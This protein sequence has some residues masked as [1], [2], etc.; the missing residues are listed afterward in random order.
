[1]KRIALLASLLV[2]PVI[3]VS[4]ELRVTEAIVFKNGL[5][6]V[7]RQ[8][9]LAFK[10][11]EARIVPA[12]D[13]L[14]GTL[15]IAAGERRV[16][17]ARASKEEVQVESEAT[18]LAALLDVNAGRKVS[19]LID[20]REYTGKL[21]QSPAPLVLLQ[22]DGKV[23]AFNRD[24]V[25]SVAFAEAPSLKVSQPES[26]TV[27]SIQAQGANES[28]PATVR[29][30][31]YGLS[32]IPEYTIEL[33]DAERARVTMKATLINDGED[34]RDARIRF[35]V[36]YPNFQFAHVPSPMTLQQ[37]L[38]QFLASLAG[39]AYGNDRFAN[40]M[41]QQLTVNYTTSNDSDRVLPGPPATGE[42]AEDLFFDDRERVT[43]AKGERAQV[44][45][46]SET[47]PF[48]HIYQ[49][50]VANEI[51]TDQVWH[52]VSVANRGTTPWTTASALVLS[53]GKPLAQDTMPYTAAGS[54]AEVKLT[55]A[56]DVAVERT[57]VEVDRKPRDL[58]RF[59]YTYD[60]VVVEGTLTITNFK[61][62][63]ITVDVT[64]DVEGQSTLRE[65]EGKV[66]RLALRPKAVNPSE[67]L[68]WQLPVAAGATRTVKYR[69]K[70]WVRE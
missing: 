14:L 4:Q 12:P 3:A 17:G 7:T 20:D 57:E 69:Y 66:T 64:K 27:L 62:E 40:A 31:R 1:M 16:D 8:G 24:S 2:L 68:E 50:T 30:L 54:S 49:W 26:R 38:Q 9:P 19:L 47:V 35:A 52:S 11:G 42:S 45:I 65:P 13:A 33:L 48:R 51:T 6:F 18:S 53:N 58:Q 5:S 15:W 36:G 37:S 32:W 22:I 43:L 34:L 21:V 25:K 67:R 61:R 39:N 55:I 10:D 23:H 63:A 59:G 28:E 46:L 60:A 70:V 41:T 44:P 56:T 29:Y